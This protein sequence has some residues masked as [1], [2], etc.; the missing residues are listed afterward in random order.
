MHGPA[1]QPPCPSSAHRSPR[2]RASYPAWPRPGLRSTRR[3]SRPACPCSRSWPRSRPTCNHHGLSLPRHLSLLSQ[4][5]PRPAG[6]G[7][8]RH[9]SVVRLPV[10]SCCCPALKRSWRLRLP[11][12]G[13]SISLASSRLLAARQRR[14]ELAPPRRAARPPTGSRRPRPIRRVGP[15]PARLRRRHGWWRLA[16]PRPAVPIGRSAPT[17]RPAAT[18]ASSSASSRPWRSPS[19]NRAA[20]A[21]FKGMT[22][23]QDHGPVLNGDDVGMARGNWRDRTPCEQMLGSLGL[24]VPVDGRLRAGARHPVPDG[25]YRTRRDEAVRSAI[26][27]RPGARFRRRAP[28]P[29]TRAAASNLRRSLSRVL[30]S[31]G[32]T[33]GA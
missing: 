7:I 19:G 18:D 22:D 13:G 5:V 4:D 33:C 24:K 9:P 14:R 25:R 6:H 8:R 27:A 12:G 20:D 23:V 16:Q 11:R 32:S 1:V 2:H 21:P 29:S 15:V 17:T 30:T 10:P 31:S 28:L 3:T 26:Y